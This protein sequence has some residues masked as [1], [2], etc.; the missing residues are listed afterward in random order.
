MTLLD[1]SMFCHSIGTRLS[2]IAKINLVSGI[3]EKSIEFLN[4]E[5]KLFKR[6]K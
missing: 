1:A 4:F 6:L 5:L 3:R 2:F